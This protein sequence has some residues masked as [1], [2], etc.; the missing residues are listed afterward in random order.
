VR[1]VL[2][3]PFV[4]AEE[5]ESDSGLRL[6]LSNILVFRQVAT[7][8]PLGEMPLVVLSRKQLRLVH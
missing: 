8:K 7:T 6:T 1:A 2:A 4:S 3:D 5:G